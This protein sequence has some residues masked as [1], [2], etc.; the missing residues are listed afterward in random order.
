MCAFFICFFIF[1]LL[2]QEVGKKP[3]NNNGILSFY[4]DDINADFIY[5]SRYLYETLFM[6]LLS[7][8]QKNQLKTI[9]NINHS[10][11]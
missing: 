6:R 2:R 9:T 1:W 5:F 10:L 4:Q 8:R 11:T 7:W 3:E